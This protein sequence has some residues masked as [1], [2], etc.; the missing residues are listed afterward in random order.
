MRLALGIL[1][2]LWLSSSFPGERRTLRTPEHAVPDGISLQCW[3]PFHVRDAA[4]ITGFYPV[5]NHSI[6]HS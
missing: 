1:G 2:G 4:F 6:V 5:V 3:G